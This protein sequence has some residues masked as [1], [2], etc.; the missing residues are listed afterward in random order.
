VKA[1]IRARTDA[2]VANIDAA[3]REVN[4]LRE[5]VDEIERLRRE[6]ADADVNARQRAS[7]SSTWH[8]ASGAR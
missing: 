1:E 5:A 2:T 6:A 8:E 3:E 7:E 4:A